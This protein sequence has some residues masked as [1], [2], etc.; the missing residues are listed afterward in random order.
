MDEDTLAN[1]FN[2]YYQAERNRRHGEGSG[3]GLGIVQQLVQAHGGTI[4]A[5]SRV[6]EGTTFR[7]TLPIAT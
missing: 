3:L 4:T 7:F 5:E 6:N 2:R 1:V